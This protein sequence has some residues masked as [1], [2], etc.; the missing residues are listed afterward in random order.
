[1]TALDWLTH[2]AALCRVSEPLTEAERVEFEQS[3]ARRAAQDE[4]ER[5]PVP[6][7]ELHA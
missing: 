3:K 2:C 5:K 4:R 6:Q 1:M 7:L